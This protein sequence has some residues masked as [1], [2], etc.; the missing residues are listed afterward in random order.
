MMYDTAVNLPTYAIAISKI[1][2]EDNFDVDQTERGMLQK[3]SGLARLAAFQGEDWDITDTA[4]YC[5]TFFVTAFSIAS[6]T[7]WD[8]TVLWNEYPRPEM[9]ETKPL[10][11]ID[12]G[13]TASRPSEW[14]LAC[15]SRMSPT[16]RLITRLTVLYETPE[17]FRWPST[18]WP[19]DN[20]FEDARAFIAKLPLAHIPE[21]E[22]RFA[23]D[24]E[25][26]FLWLG[27]NIHIDLGLYGT[28]TYSYF[29]YNGEGQEIQ[30]ENVLASNGLAQAIKNMLT[31]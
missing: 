6:N 18:A 4:L 21:P 15:Q 8:A 9:Y 12:V 22:I 11:D 31:A 1:V 13:E 27:E 24:G 20:A 7:P 25:I 2:G 5:D 16:L 17:D 10:D 3:R 26:N 19:I 23:D 29:G 28:G 30:D 14:M